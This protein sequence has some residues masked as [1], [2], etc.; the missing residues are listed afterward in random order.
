MEIWKPIPGHEG[1]YEASNL[2]RI[3]SLRLGNTKTPKILKGW[4]T[5]KGYLAVHLDKS[6]TVHKLIALTFIGPKPEDLTVDHINKDKTD[7]RP[8]N[9]RYITGLENTS[10]SKSVEVSIS[11]NDINLTFKSLSEASKHIGCS[12]GHLS[13]QAKKNKLVK[14]WLISYE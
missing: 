9:L 3:K 11:K 13:G 8:E 12:K 10:R 4:K 6:M 14:G 7:N 2:G 1:K 5:K